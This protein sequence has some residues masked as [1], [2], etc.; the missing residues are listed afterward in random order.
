[1]GSKNLTDK[2]I[3]QLA[4]KYIEGTAT[5]EEKAM[6]HEWYDTVNAGST[7]TVL[8]DTPATAETFRDEMFASLQQRIEQERGRVLEM[9]HRSFSWKY[10]AAAILVLI[11]GIS[12]Y[13]NLNVKTIDEQLATTNFSV[14]E[15]IAPQATRAVI[16]LSDGNRLYL[17]SLSD[18]IIAFEGNARVVKKADGV[19]YQP[20]LDTKTIHYNVLTVPRGSRLVNLT[21]SDG[22]RIWLNAE[23]SMR[24]PVNFTG[25]TRNVEIT[26]EAYFEVSRDPQR[27]FYVSS[28]GLT[29]EVLG[30]HFNVNTYADEPA[31]KIT[32]LEGSVH[33]KYA[34]GGDTMLKPGEQASVS[35]SSTLLVEKNIDTQAVIAWK[36]ENFMMK[37]TDLGALARQMARWYDIQVMFEGKVP[38]RKFGGSISRNVNLSTMLKALQESGIESEFE[39]GKLIIR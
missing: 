13:L 39:E 25:A 38:N 10:A 20:T 15:V 3:S 33:V 24:Y 2:E 26:G 19:V 14:T 11:V 23:S 5:A 35:E 6:L 36:N 18:G 17:D 30:T 32:L 22:S 4:K 29:T 27:R 9:P 34:R 12:V 1:M 37:G 31:M 28:R 7:E 21:L 8:V 16:T